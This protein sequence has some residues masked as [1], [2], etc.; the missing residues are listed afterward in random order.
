MHQVYS[1]SFKSDL[2]V[3]I[4]LDLEGRAALFA[5]ALFGCSKEHNC[6]TLFFRAT[7]RSSSKCRNG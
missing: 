6:F 2:Y 4:L 7:L 1:A 3:F 5:L